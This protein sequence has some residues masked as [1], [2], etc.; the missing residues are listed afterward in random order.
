MSCGGKLS[1]LVFVVLWHDSTT[2]TKTFTRIIKFSHMCDDSNTRSQ[3]AYY[4][5]DV[6]DWFLSKEGS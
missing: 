4:M 3:D 2:E 5:A 6:W 1:N